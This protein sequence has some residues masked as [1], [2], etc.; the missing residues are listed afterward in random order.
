MPRRPQALWAAAALGLAAA[1]AGAELRRAT[2]AAE[3]L[4]A[5]LPDWGTRA[6]ISQ[7]VARR[8]E[9]AD[10]GRVGLA[11][12]SSSATEARANASEQDWGLRAAAGQYLAR[13]G[14]SNA[15]KKIEYGPGMHN[16]DP[17]VGKVFSLYYSSYS[18][19]Q[20]TSVEA[21]DTY[22]PVQK[23]DGYVFLGST[24]L[25]EPSCNLRLRSQTNYAT[26]TR[27]ANMR[28]AAIAICNYL[29]TNFQELPSC[30]ESADQVC[31]LMLM[32]PFT[33]SDELQEPYTAAAVALAAYSKICA[34]G[35][36]PYSSY[37]CNI[38]RSGSVIC[39]GLG[40]SGGSVHLT[41]LPSPGLLDLK[42]DDA[43]MLRFSKVFLAE[44]GRSMYHETDFYYRLPDPLAWTHTPPEAVFCPDLDCLVSW[45]ITR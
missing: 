10:Y 20:A 19:E 1:A 8:P 40:I 16:V 11:V 24:M 12:H 36:D 35:R 23:D 39:A 14:H 25:P 29:A 21:T 37:Q 6:V 28:L 27:D 15:S 42:L 3:P 22:A 43:Y 5:R 17:A 34:L 33:S 30:N 32:V 2:V 18:G 45:F 7:D 44:E 31:E 9:S 13:H 38:Q 41:S 4:G 26:D